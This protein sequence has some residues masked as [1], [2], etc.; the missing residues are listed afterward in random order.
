VYVDLIAKLKE[1]NLK[2]PEIEKA[3]T[4]G[5][6]CTPQLVQDIQKYLNV[7]KMCSMYG[8]TEVTSAAFQS[9]PHDSN[10]SL[11]H[12]VGYIC[13]HTEAKVIDS[14]GNIVPFGQPG[15]L[16]IRSYLTFL[17]Y[18]DDEEKTKEV[19]GADKWLKTGDQF[20]LQENG[21]GQIVGRFKEMIIRGGENIFPK[22]IEDFLNTH[23]NVK[24]THVVG[25]LSCGFSSVIISE[26]VLCLG[27][28]DDRMG[29][30]VAA[31]IRLNDADKGLSYDDVKSF[32][33]G[34]LAHF[35]V[36]R[37]I[38][39]VDEF[40]RTVSGKVQK[41]KFIDYFKNEIKN[42]IEGRQKSI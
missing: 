19:L 20:V 6:I 29:E 9:L 12:S 11:Q 42:A 22:E 8:Q 27:L 32:C 15:E 24:E 4:A 21:Y 7:R 30:E 34:S 10:E 13:D 38:I 40:P 25:M 1:L 17:D 3:N 23:P 26:L 14:N 28:N 41:F 35:K 18:F 33:S 16:C 31:F 39:I 36:P 2:L 5:A 37:Y